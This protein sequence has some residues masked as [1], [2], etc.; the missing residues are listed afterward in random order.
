MAVAQPSSAA[1]VGWSTIASS[2]IMVMHELMTLPVERALF[3]LVVAAIASSVAWALGHHAGQARR[4]SSTPT[5]EGLLA[6]SH[7]HSL[8]D[9]AV[10]RVVA[11]RECGAHEQSRR[12]S[13]ALMAY[14][15][16][17]DGL[18]T[19]RAALMQAMD[20]SDET[21]RPWLVEAAP[22]GKGTDNA[23]RRLAPGSV[24]SGTNE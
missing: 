1:P 12:L 11:L 8:F 14:G 9:D 4:S 2:S 15:G 23:A 7:H 21:L 17:M 24:G 5:A 16:A 18:R 22:L 19:A 3:A 13:V 10:R 20:S 6:A